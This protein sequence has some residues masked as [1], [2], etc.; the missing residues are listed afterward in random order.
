MN[1]PQPH[2]I[3]PDARPHIPSLAPAQATAPHPS[4]P[5]D[6]VPQ[7]VL[8]EATI[9]SEPATYA[10]SCGAKNIA[11]PKRGSLKALTLLALACSISAH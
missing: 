8:L 10:E 11:S 6:L 7:F 5:A 4:P 1:Q 2:L 9:K 3:G